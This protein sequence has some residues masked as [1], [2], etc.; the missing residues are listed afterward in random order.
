MIINVKND[1][2]IQIDC[3]QNIF[4]FYHLIEFIIFFFK[5]N[6]NC[7]LKNR[8]ILLLFLLWIAE[9]RTFLWL[10]NL[11][12][13]IALPIW[14][15]LKLFWLDSKILGLLFTFICQYKFV[16]L[17][18]KINFKNLQEILK[19]NFILFIFQCLITK[20]AR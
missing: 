12:K 17:F 8:R 15:S 11:F 18:I 13:Q 14:A 20:L 2:L 7:K 6:I 9:P 5:L 3:N 4:Y 16:V 1:F 10:E 19:I